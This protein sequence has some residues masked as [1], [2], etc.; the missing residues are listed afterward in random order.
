MPEFA[1]TD[2]VDRLVADESPVAAA[3]GAVVLVIGSV[4]L[5]EHALAAGARV[6]AF[7]DS[8]LDHVQLPDGVERV[9]PEDD[10]PD[11]DV[12]WARLP[13]DLD[14]LDQWCA[15]VAGAGGSFVAGARTRHLHPTMNQV[16]GRHFGAVRASLGRDK[17]RVLH[18]SDPQPAAADRPGARWPRWRDLELPGDDPGQVTRT[19]RH[20]GTFASGRLDPGTRLLLQQLD[21]VVA[22]G[23]GRVLDWGSGAGL[24]TTALGRRLPT[25][26]LDAV[27]LSWAG[28]EATRLTL[29]ANGIDATTHW[30]DGNALLAG[31]DGLDLV[32]SNPPFHAGVAKDSTAT[33]TMIDLAAERLVPG[34]ELW[35]VHN[36]H[37]PWLRQLRRHGRAEVI[38]QDPGYTVSRL[39]R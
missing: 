19:A 39:R 38:A 18:G 24:L 9:T 5:A 6:L 10:L 7:C 15:W 33:E 12:A 29:A 11:L 35:L 2:P 31:L 3:A 13:R 36:S 16:I 30:A 20:G 1:L 26:T 17:S 14:E 28:A 22:S 8:A 27:D 21:Q 25:A 37:L 34:G 23:P 32:I 4:P